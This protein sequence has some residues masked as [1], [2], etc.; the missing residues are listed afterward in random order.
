MSTDQLDINNDEMQIIVPDSDLKDRVMKPGSNKNALKRAV[1][2]A[3]VAIEELSVEFDDWMQ[4]EL[5]KLFDQLDVVKMNGLGSEA[6][7]DLFN[8]IHDM[9]GHAT[10]LGFPNIT[11]ICATL[12]QLLENIPDRSRIS[13]KVIEIHAQAIK[14]LINEEKNESFETKASAIS[15]GLRQM[16][17]KIIKQE[18]ERENELETVS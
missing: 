6:G 3:E 7:E 2:A 4:S 16:V 9:K 1:A 17:M 8:I 5:D 11:D 14:T 15:L 13:I 12:C 18:L 10:T